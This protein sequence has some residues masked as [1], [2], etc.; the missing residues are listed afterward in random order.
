MK[1]YT[2][3]CESGNELWLQ[4]EAALQWQSFRDT[5][6]QRVIPPK[7]H[8][9]PPVQLRS[10]I[11]ICLTTINLFLLIIAWT[12]N[13]ANCSCSSQLVPSNPPGQYFLFM[14]LSLAV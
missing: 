3:N 13:D 5:E 8:E 2:T 1:L 4:G 10:G 12:S 7:N 6:P 14:C 9:M 11:H